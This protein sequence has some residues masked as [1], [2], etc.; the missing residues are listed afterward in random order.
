MEKEDLIENL[1]DDLKKKA[2][3]T[4]TVE[5]SREEDG[6]ARMDLHEAETQLYF[7]W[8]DDPE[9]IKECLEELD[10]VWD[11]L[12]NK[13]MGDGIYTLFVL[14]KSITDGDGCRYW[15]YLEYE[16]H[17]IEYYQTKEEYAK[18]QESFVDVGRFNF[19]N[20]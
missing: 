9:Q 2:L 19:F 6:S 14:F 5:I 15:S 13:E 18:A 11:N 1:I 10:E 12:L 8:H 7:G 3:Y 16:T 20:I 17:R 4:V